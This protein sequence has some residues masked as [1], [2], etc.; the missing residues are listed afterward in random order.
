MAVILTVAKEKEDG[1]LALVADVWPRS[2]LGLDELC[3]P[4]WL[5]PRRVSEYE[6]GMDTWCGR[7]TSLKSAP[8]TAHAVRL[9]MCLEDGASSHTQTP[10]DRTILEACVR[11]VL[12]AR[13]YVFPTQYINVVS[14][15]C[16][17][18]FKVAAIERSE[19]EQAIKLPQVIPT[20]HL[21]TLQETAQL[22]RSTHILLNT[23]NQKPSPAPIPQSETAYAALGGLDAQVE[24]VR[25]LVEMPLRHPELFREF[26]LKPPRGLLL[27]G[28]PGT[29]K[30]TLAHSAAKACASS[31]I[32]ISGPELSSSL[33][34][35]TE[36]AL[37]KVF[38]QARQSAPS[39]II[40][41]EI[42]ALAPRRDGESADVEK[43]VVA[44]LLTLL[45]GLSRDD[46]RVVIIAATNRP[47]AL[48]PALRRPG[49]LDKEIEVG[50]PSSDARLSILSVLLHNVPHTLS[51]EHVRL[52]A[53]QTHGYVGAD[54]SSL[55]REAG[56][57]A[58]RRHMA[59]A[60]ELGPRMEQLSLQSTEK[61]EGVRARHGVGVDDFNAARATIRPSAMREI[62]LEMPKVSWN[63]IAPG[64]S[65]LHVQQRVRECVEWPLKYR[66]TMQALGIDPPRGVLLYGPPGCSK[67]LIARALASESGLNFVAVKGPEVR[68]SC[69]ISASVRLRTDAAILI[70]SF[71]T[72]TWA[73]QSVRCERSFARRAQP[74]RP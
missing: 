21:D 23:S 33:H 59:E 25:Q 11:D 48:D 56:M 66:D 38:A 46:A 31:I 34:G 62:T 64:E 22:G 6:S 32:T 74:L 69:E 72:S 19:G 30:T 45:D 68:I 16:R 4:G 67:T 58:L 9:E 55:V 53:S 24:E 14:Q 27:F 57:R 50:I 17:H 1:S 20:N 63:D 13:K 15:E 73:N 10:E 61:Q 39:V 51:D 18:R 42:D 49:R 3:V 52:I 28:P 2:S 60:S 5:L 40:I 47:N 41:D 70:P 44:S 8:P 7:V 71:S 35:G 43:R 54:L 65:G 36:R 26:G 12:L 37:R 29:G